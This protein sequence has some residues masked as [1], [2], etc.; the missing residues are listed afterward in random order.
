MKINWSNRKNKLLNHKINIQRKIW[1]PFLS[2]IPYYRHTENGRGIKL[3][4]HAASSLIKPSKFKTRGS[5]LHWGMKSCWNQAED[6]EKAIEQN[7]SK[8]ICLNWL[9]VSLPGNL[10]LV[11]KIKLFSWR[12]LR[13]LMRSRL[14]SLFF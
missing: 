13:A 1:H 6:K 7:D 14:F 4:F 2:S 3:S 11:F 10:L 8:R 12:A 9:T 5:N